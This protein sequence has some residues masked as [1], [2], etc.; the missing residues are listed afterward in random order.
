MGNKGVF[1]FCLVLVISLGFVS[2]GFGDFWGKITGKVVG[3]VTCND[4][5]GRYNYLDSGYVN[6]GG[7]YYYDFCLVN[8][9]YDYGCPVHSEAELAPSNPLTGRAI[10][11]AY[12]IEGQPLLGSKDCSDYGSNYE[13]IKGACVVSNVT[14]ECYNDSD[15]PPEIIKGCIGNNFTIYTTYFSC[16]GGECV[17]SGGSGGMGV[18]SEG[19][20]CEE[21]V[22]I[23][24]QT[25]QT[26]TVCSGGE[27]IT[28]EGPGANQ[29]TYDWDCGTNQTNYTC[30]NGVCESWETDS[31]CP[32][33]CCP[34][35]NNYCYD[36]D[37]DNV[38]SAGYVDF[39]CNRYYDDCYGT[40][41][42]VLEKICV[43]NS[44]TAND[45]MQCPNGYFCQEGACIELNQTQECEL[46]VAT[47]STSYIEEGQQVLL[48]VQGTD[49]CDGKNLSFTVWEDDFLGDDPVTL[50]PF[51][52]TF[53]GGAG[54]G[55]W[56]AEYQD[57]AS[58]NPEY[59]FIA[60]VEG[61]SIQSNPPN[62]EVYESNSTQEYHA[63]CI[64]NVT[65]GL[66]QC[67]VVEGPGANQCIYDWECGGGNETGMEVF[68][69]SIDFGI[70]YEEVM[71]YRSSDS[72]IKLMNLESI[73]A[74]EGDTDSFTESNFQSF[75]I[76]SQPINQNMPSGEGGGL[77]TLYVSCSGGCSGS[78][79]SEGCPSATIECPPDHPADPR[80]CIITCPDQNCYIPCLPAPCSL[81]YRLG[82][83]M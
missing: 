44:S 4:S 50:N 56:I 72:Q 68:L 17:E 51:P 3:D 57:D 64:V 60:N 20:I 18:C 42:G 65:T 8:K 67:V 49:G 36:S 32:E 9:A 39:N 27:C 75:E 77:T 24:N 33:D 78:C 5:D 54:I 19:T 46:E 40:D 53:I 79:G 74:F 59:Y 11:S 16:V 45:Q 37:G 30:G 28:I 63:T 38:F 48:I 2:A 35:Y 70:N 69:E 34:T 13:C 41:L 62:L 10:K 25:N 29:C 61:Q 66:D 26:H 71:I 81:N 76:K 43:G 15:C 21:G 12:E 22:C 7:V 80:E 47:W 52:V 73:N 55:S 23:S 82:N 1:V 14:Q 31:G 58:G 83:I 6:Y